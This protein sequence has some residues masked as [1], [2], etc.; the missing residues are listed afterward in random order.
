MIKRPYGIIY[1]TGPTGSGKSTTLYSSLAEINDV[2][3]NI[4]TVEDPIEY[5]LR[6][7]NQIQVNPDI[8]LDFAR[9]LRAFLRQDPDIILVGETRYTE[10]AKI[11][12]EAALTGHLVFTTLHANDAPG[13]FMRLTEMGIE[14]FLVSASIIGVVA[15]RLVRKICAKCKERYSDPSALEYLGLPAHTQLYRGRGCDACGSTGYKGRVGVCEVLEVTEEIRRLIAEG[16]DT[17][18]IRD[19]AIAAGMRSLREY[20]LI[21]LAE[22]LI[23]AE[24]LLRTVVV[25]G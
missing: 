17:M 4:S 20:C 1:V 10:T 15:Q 18:I 22:G 7:V 2:R 16:A 21:L 8:G 5:D 11:A 25:Q 19:A 12:V 6:G 14:P 3:R 24:E 23:S 9:V 13:T